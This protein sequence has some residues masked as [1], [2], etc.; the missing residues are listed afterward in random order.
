MAGGLNVND[1]VLVVPELFINPAF[2]EA[3]TDFH[4]YSKNCFIEQ[5][6]A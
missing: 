6:S 4:R 2:L 5:V 1:T 3:L